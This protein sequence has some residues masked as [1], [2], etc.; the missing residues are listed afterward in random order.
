MATQTGTR[1]EISCANLCDDALEK[2]DS[3]LL[4]S[5]FPSSEISSDPILS[6]RGSSAKCPKKLLVSAISK[7]ATQTG[8]RGEI[9]CANLCDDALE[10][11]DSLLGLSKL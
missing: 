2:V 1:G 3:L 8:T 5:F 10:K 4:S 7:M 9:S 11:V 6:L